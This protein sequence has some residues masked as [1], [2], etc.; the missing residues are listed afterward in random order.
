[1]D[2]IWNEQN[3]ESSKS[4]MDKIPNGQKSGFCPIRDFHTIQ[5]A[6]SLNSKL[7]L[8][9]RIGFLFSPS[10][11]GVTVMKGDSLKKRS[12][13]VNFVTLIPFSYSLISTD[14][15][16]GFPEKSFKQKLDF[17]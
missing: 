15:Q 9:G 10:G 17:C 5:F 11:A 13:K 16:R 8:S 4:R 12:F 2:K 6:V 7:T 1:M 14:F 3:P